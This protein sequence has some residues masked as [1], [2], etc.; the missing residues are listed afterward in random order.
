MLDRD[1]VTAYLPFCPR[2]AAVR[3]ALAMK[4]SGKPSRSSS[5]ISMS[6]AF[7]SLSTFW[8]KCVASVA[9]RSS[10]AAK[11]ALA[12][13]CSPAPARVKLR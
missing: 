3:A 12:S 4:K 9:S 1:S 7:S 10:I 8:P 13:G 11:R 6:Q 2:S 5:P